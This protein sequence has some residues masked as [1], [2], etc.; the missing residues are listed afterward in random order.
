LNL[1]PFL[2][3]DI[4]F[5]KSDV[6]S[7]ILP[8]LTRDNKI[9][10]LPIV[11]EPAILKYNSEQFRNSGV[12]AP[13]G[14][15]VDSFTDSLKTLKPNPEDPAPFVA[16]NTGGAHLF[17]LMAAYGGLPLD[18]RTD[19]PTI[20]YTDPT[21][22]DAIRQVLDLAKKGYIKY[23]ALGS[24]LSSFIANSSGI[25]DAAVFTDTANVF[26]FQVKR[27]NDSDSAKQYKPVTYPKGNQYS[28]VSYTIGSAYIS[29][30]SQN[31][32]AC[33]RWISTIAQHPELFSLMPA[34]H[35]LLSDPTVIANEGEAL[36]ALYAE[37]DTLLQ[38]PNTISIPATFGGN[39]N[40]TGL[41]LQHWLFQAFDN[42]VLSDG[43]LDTGLQKAESMSKGFQDCAV[44]LPP[45]D[46]TSR[47]SARE[48]IK[49]YGD[50]ATKVD[51]SLKPIFALLQ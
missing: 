37:I 51:P 43:D 49:Q 7:G 5:D 18:Y 16:Q 35:S 6:I 17:I 42:Y 1:D 32:E 39:A 31:A 28:A 40:P 22:V 47:D 38:D 44:N 14:W 8:Q 12:P 29:A 19:P 30:T 2:S 33:Y 20:N 50:C 24:L 3:E 41:L 9:W 25:P 10:A 13:E 34:R 26:S 48:Y 27:Q 45:L 36:A 11:I 15:T 46:L 23:D 21:T 4:N